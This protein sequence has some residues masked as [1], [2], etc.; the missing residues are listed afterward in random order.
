M[1]TKV[2]PEKATAPDE[3]K[4]SCQECPVKVWTSSMRELEGGLKGFLPD[5]FWRHRRAAKKE[6]LLAIRSLLDAAIERLEKEPAA[7]VRKASV[8]IAVQ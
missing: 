3:E 2:K 6:A 7:R 5:E 4:E 8:K 1:E